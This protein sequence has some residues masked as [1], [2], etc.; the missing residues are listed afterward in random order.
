MQFPR[1][2]SVHSAFTCTDSQ[3]IWTGDPLVDANTGIV[4]GTDGS[5]VPDRWWVVSLDQ[6]GPLGMGLS[7][8]D[9]SSRR[10]TLLL[11]WYADDHW[12]V[13]AYVSLS[14]EMLSDLIRSTGFARGANKLLDKA[15]LST[16]TENAAWRGVPR[17]ISASATGSF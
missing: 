6:S 15:Y 7:A 1:R 11:D 8:K 16:I 2:T 14:G 5:G 4:T 17:A 3:Y 9:T 10:V 13:H 12:L